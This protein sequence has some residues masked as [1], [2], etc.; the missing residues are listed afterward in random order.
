[1]HCRCLIGPVG[2]LLQV[3]IMVSVPRQHA[4]MAA[5]Q[6]VPPGVQATLLVDT[7]ATCTTLD[8]SIIQTLQLQPTGNVQVHTPSTGST[9]VTQQL[10]DIG[11]VLVGQSP[12]G[13]PTGHMMQ[14]LPVLESDFSAQSIEGLIGRD[15]LA[16]CRMT[17]A[18]PDGLMLLS[19]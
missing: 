18:G 6:P 1:M 4:L 3:S 12:N 19:F 15:V 17:Y 14:S 7:G 9:P 5:G 11:L 16:Q 8:R 2:P 13:M 10:Y